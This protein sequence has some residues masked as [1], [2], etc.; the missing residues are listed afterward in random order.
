MGILSLPFFGITY[1]FILYLKF[2]FSMSTL[3]VCALAVNISAWVF[4]FI[5]QLIFE[6]KSP[7]V[8]DNL[9]QPL[10]L[11]PYFVLFEIMFVLGYEQE[12]EKSVNESGKLLRRLLDIRDEQ[13][14][15]WIRVQ[16]DFYARTL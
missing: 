10:V 15:N 4:Q 3:L 1:L 16:A 11:A 13:A 5:G 6:K 14:R 12:L 9:V 8:F 7:A 2:S